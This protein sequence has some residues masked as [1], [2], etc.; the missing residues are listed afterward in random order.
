M[1]EK[2]F[3]IRNL[4]IDKVIYLNNVLIYINRKC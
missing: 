2:L 1:I 3:D 4:L